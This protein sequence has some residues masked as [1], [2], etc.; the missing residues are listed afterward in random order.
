MINYC[1]TIDEM[2][3]LTIP[4]LDCELA[5]ILGLS[6]D[7]G[8]RRVA[9][10]TADCQPIA[11]PVKQRKTDGFSVKLDV[12]HFQPEDLTIKVVDNDL[13]VIGKHGERLDEN[14][15]V[16]RQFSR[17]YELPEGIDLERMTS[18]L[19]D[20]RK[21]CIEAPIIQKEITKE[22]VI[23]ITVVHEPNELKNDPKCDTTS[24][25]NKTVDAA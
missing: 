16:S 6:V 20:D 5:R 11:P 10:R 21:L 8:N 2:L 17:R 13:V 24:E 22:R 4:S 25:Q 18:K 1:K 15:Y 12:T 19:T 3:Y 23:P 7:N 14:G 9:K